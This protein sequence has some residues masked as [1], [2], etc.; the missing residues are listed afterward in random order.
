MGPCWQYTATAYG[1]GSDGGV[2]ETLEVGEMW[3][4]V[5]GT[6]EAAA[7]KTL[8][9]FKAQ[10]LLSVCHSFALLHGWFKDQ[11]QQKQE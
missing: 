11:Q 9:V 4:N 3:K 1:E 2:W 7:V 10:F 6:Q 5:K 8:I